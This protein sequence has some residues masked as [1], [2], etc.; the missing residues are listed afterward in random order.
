ML[1]R[2]IVELFLAF[3]GTG[4]LKRLGVFKGHPEAAARS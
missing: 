4:I 2:A 1:G 3:A